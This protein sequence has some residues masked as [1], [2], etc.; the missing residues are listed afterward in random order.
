[1][2]LALAAL[3][4]V[5][6]EWKFS[7]VGQDFLFAGIAALLAPYLVMDFRKGTATLLKS[8]KKV[9]RSDEP[10]GFWMATVM[11]WM[12]LV[13]FFVLGVCGLPGLRKY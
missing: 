11:N 6:L 5:L 9:R 1:V 7:G 13:L 4:A 8:F 2:L 12:L 10:E 3:F